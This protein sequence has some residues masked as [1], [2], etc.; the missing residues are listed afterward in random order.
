MLINEIL[1][2][3]MKYVLLESIGM[4]FVKVQMLSRWRSLTQLAPVEIMP[5]PLLSCFDVT[6]PSEDYG[7]STYIDI[8]D[9]LISH[10]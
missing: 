2:F 1:F 7:I 6:S 3:R 10:A 4:T 8:R 5:Q 9:Y